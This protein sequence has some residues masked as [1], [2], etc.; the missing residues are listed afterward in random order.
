MLAWAALTFITAVVWPGV[1]CAFAGG[2]DSSTAPEEKARALLDA[3]LATLKG[4]QRGRVEPIT[5]EAL[6]QAL[7]S[8]SFFVVRFRDYPVRSA[9]PPLKSQNVFVVA[10]KAGTVQRVSDVEALQTLFRSALAPVKDESKAKEALRAWLRV[11][12]EFYQD[13]FMQFALPAENRST[14]FKGEELRVSGDA[15]ATKGGDGKITA[16]L[17]FDKRG[18]LVEAKTS[19]RVEPKGA[20]PAGPGR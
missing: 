15:V 16:T 4:A 8:L 11:V 9:P 13:G 6:A 17:A 2:S 14:A 19:G 10:A 5:D 1:L 18:K 7:P 12:E 20:R 3:H